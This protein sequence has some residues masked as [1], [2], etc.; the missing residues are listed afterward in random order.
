M[1]AFFAGSALVKPTL[2][3]NAVN[4]HLVRFNL[5]PG[6]LHP[7]TRI[8][9]RPSPYRRLRRTTIRADL[10]GRN[11]KPRKGRT[12]EAVIHGEKAESILDSMSSDQKIGENSPLSGP[13]LFSPAR[14]IKLECPASRPLDHFV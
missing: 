11:D 3:R 13:P 1:Q 10:D 14:K 4:Q 9:W 2:F 8:V 12:I 6:A 7:G 5:V